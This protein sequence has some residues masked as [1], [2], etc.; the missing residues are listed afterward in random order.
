MAITGFRLVG[1]A[2]NVI[3]ASTVDVLGSANISVGDVLQIDRYAE[4]QALVR[5]PAST[6]G[7]ITLFGVAAS[8][9]TSGTGQVKVIPIV[10]GQLWEAG[11]T[12]DLAVGQQ[13]KRHVLTDH[14]TIANTAVDQS[15]SLG[16]FLMLAISSTRGSAC[17]GEFIRFG[18]HMCVA[19][20]T[21]QEY[22]E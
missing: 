1:A 9:L 13:L 4:S 11:C 19:S 8:A 21:T 18:Q 12:N 10:Q 22:Y 7:P 17:I 14:D 16:I 20:G 2:G 3:E 6:V 15:T 5:R